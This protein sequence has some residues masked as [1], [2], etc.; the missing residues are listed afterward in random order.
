MVPKGAHVTEDS[1]LLPGE[2]SFPVAARGRALAGG[3]WASGPVEGEAGPRP[4]QPRR[5]QAA[6]GTS[7]LE[8]SVTSSRQP[9]GSRLSEQHRAGRPQLSCPP[10]SR[11]RRQ[12][13]EQPGAEARFAQLRTRPGAS[14]FPSPGSARLARP[15]PTHR[16]GAGRG[17]PRRAKPAL[18]AQ[19]P[20]PPATGHGCPGAADGKADPAA[21]RWFQ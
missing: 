3:A 17:S 15:L 5:P 12:C 4:V 9:Q 19:A 20:P 7:G 21:A 2:P 13:E 6:P 18:P 11:N 8:Q 1:S 14:P 10:A 16:S